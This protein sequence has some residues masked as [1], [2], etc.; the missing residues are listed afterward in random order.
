MARPLRPG[1]PDNGRLRH[2]MQLRDRD[3]AA[4]PPAQLAELELGERG[5][6]REAHALPGRA[7]RAGAFELALPRVMGALREADRA[8]HGIDDLRRADL[9]R[10][11]GEG[12]AP[13]GAAR[14]P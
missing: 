7:D 8:L 6:N 12:V 3:G 4:I 10:R 2:A 11:A 13:L 9:G 14:G 5:T 1:A